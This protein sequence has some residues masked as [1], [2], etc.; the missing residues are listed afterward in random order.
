MRY[1]TRMMRRSV[2]A[3]ILLYGFSSGLAS[4][5]AQRGAALTASDGWVKLPA[6][7]ATNAMAFAS[8]NNP[9]MYDA[10]LVSAASDAATKV[11]LRDASKGTDAVTDVTVPA[12]DA[13]YM[14]EKGLHIALVGLK[15]PLKEGDTV[16]ITLTTE[17]GLK[18][19]VSAVVKK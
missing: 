17:L 11:E 2:L 5:L 16:A 10:Y 12:H 8:V 19:N 4:V 14:D 6:A 9:G 3:L 1:A 13:L 7:G 15:A 18:I